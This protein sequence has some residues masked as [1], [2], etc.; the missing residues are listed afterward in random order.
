[1]VSCYQAAVRQETGNFTD[2]SY[3]NKKLYPPVRL[4]CNF[5]L[6]NSQSLDLKYIYDVEKGAVILPLFTNLM[7]LTQPSVPKDPSV[8]N[9]KKK[10]FSSANFC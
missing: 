9:M 8:E 7:I 4:S 6:N 1:M 3:V 2:L 5:T 10:D